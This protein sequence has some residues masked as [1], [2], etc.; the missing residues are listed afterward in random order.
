MNK[1]GFKK[2]DFTFNVRSIFLFAV[3][4]NQYLIA[5]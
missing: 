2:I 4:K 5:D 1:F 3:L